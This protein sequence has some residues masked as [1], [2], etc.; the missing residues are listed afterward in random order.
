MSWLEGEGWVDKW[1]ESE[2]T[3]RPEGPMADKGPGADATVI[4]S[5]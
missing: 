3:A 1:P 4:F 5:S 2:T